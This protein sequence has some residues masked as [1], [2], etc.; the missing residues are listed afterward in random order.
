M[1]YFVGGFNANSF[2]NNVQVYDA[3]NNS[4]SNGASMPTARAYLG[5]V[6]VNDVLYAI[7]GFDGTNWLST[8]EQYTPIGY[9]TA[10]P[11]IQINSPGNET[12]SKV[13]LSYTVNRNAAW[14]GYSLDDTANITVNGEIELS[15][16]TQ[17][18]H[19][20]V[21]YANDSCRQHGQL[22][23]SFLL[24]RFSSP[25]H[26]H[27]DAAEPVLR[28]NRYP[29]DFHLEPKRHPSSLTA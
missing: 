8:V 9:G 4:W 3:A 23:Q 18:E 15:N 17:G 27:A 14:V 1:L 10:P 22:K 19:S 28:V 12:Y 21:L 7:G 25:R 2:S 5:V 16:L 24:C 11:I 6:V 26:Q 29:V 20:I 13:I